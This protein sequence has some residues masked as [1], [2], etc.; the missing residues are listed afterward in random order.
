MGKKN[1]QEAKA[2]EAKPETA[3]VAEE[4]KEAPA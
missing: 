4:A 2:P 3:P 1:K